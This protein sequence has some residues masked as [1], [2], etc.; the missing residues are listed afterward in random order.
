MQSA[1]DAEFGLPGSRSIRISGQI[2]EAR[3]HPQPIGAG[4]ASDPGT[5]DDVRLPAKAIGRGSWLALAR[6]LAWS[7]CEQRFAEGP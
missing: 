2:R 5:G 7:W 3:C 1:R 4:S 6:A